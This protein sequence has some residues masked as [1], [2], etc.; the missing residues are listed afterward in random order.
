[1]SKEK[2]QGPEQGGDGYKPI[3]DLYDDEEIRDILNSASEDVQPLFE[4]SDLD[5]EVQAAKEKA[6]SSSST[7]DPETSNNLFYRK[8]QRLLSQFLPGTR[9]TN[10]ANRMVRDEITLFLNEGHTSGRDSRQAYIH[11]LEE[12]VAMLTAWVNSGG[13]DLYALYQLFYDE[14]VKREYR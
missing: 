5:D 13:S 12:A 7:Q 2:N 1:M 4:F 8:K 9:E 6:T 14:N 11:Q 10:L 3:S